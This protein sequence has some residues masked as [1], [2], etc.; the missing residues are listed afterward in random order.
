MSQKKRRGITG[1]GL[2]FF[3]LG[4]WA[5][6]FSL[7]GF[8][9]LC[10]EAVRAAGG[11]SYDQLMDLGHSLTDR[12]DYLGARR[13]YQRALKKAW[14]EKHIVSACASLA[15]VAFYMGD[16][17]TAKDY[18]EKI[19]AINSNHAWAREWL[20][21]A[22]ERLPR[23]PVRYTYRDLMKKADALHDIGEVVKA[24]QMYLEADRLAVSRHEKIRAAASLAATFFE[25]G[26]YQAARV[27]CW[28]VL[29]L[30]P[31]NRWAGNWLRKT[32]KRLSE[33][34]PAPGPTGGK[35]G[36][37]PEQEGVGSRR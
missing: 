3:I 6:V 26:E 15:A 18:C 29:S 2:T 22:V 20:A 9:G 33:N 7:V 8:S 28:R 4:L 34:L 10:P 25:L 31:D 12:G 30:D 1:Y 16:Y 14:G 24:H 5:L 37:F 11:P 35:K 27:C 19:L 32:E 17:P 36:F 13:A 21:K 23:S